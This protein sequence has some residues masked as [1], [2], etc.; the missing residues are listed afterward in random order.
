MSNLSA[1][2]PFKILTLALVVGA[3]GQLVSSALAQ[4]VQIASPNNRIKALL[5]P[6]ATGGLTYRVTV[7]GKSA[8]EPSSLGITVDGQNLGQQAV[9]GKPTTGN[10]KETYAV[11]GVH[12][13][14]VNSYHEAIF[15]LKS[16]D[17]KMPWQLEVRVFDD[18]VALRYRVPAQGQ[19][20]IGGETTT[21][22]LP[23]GSVVWYQTNINEYENAFQ[24]QQVER[25]ATD[26]VIGTPLTAKLPHGLGYA[27]VTEANLVKYSNLSL[28]AHGDQTFGAYFGSDKDGWSSDG[29]IVSPWRVTM[30]A[31]DLNGLVNSDLLRNLCPPPAPELANATWIKPGRGNWHWLVTGHPRLEAQN[32]WVD[33]T[34]KLGFEYYLIDDGWRDWK[35]GDKGQWENIKDVVNYATPHGVKIWAWVNS[36]EVFSPTDRAAYFQKAKDVGLVGLKIDFPERPNSTWVQWYD[37]TLRDAAKYQLMIDFHGAVKPTGRERTW[38]NELTREAILG[39]ESGKLPASHD[40]ALP[41]TR[42]VQ[43]H[44][45]FTPTDFRAG[46]LNGSSWTHELAQAIVYTSPFLCYGGSPENYLQNPGVDILKALPST[47]DETIVLPGSEV[48]RTAAFARRKGREWFIGVVNG[49]EDRPFHINLDFLTKGPFEA[50]TMTDLA[51]NNA[52]W[53]RAQKTVTGK[54][55]LTFNVRG[56]GGFVARLMP[57][58]R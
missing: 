15:P 35:S 54:D 31:P 44:A 52:G 58:G 18:G 21:W 25:M 19:H 27:F 13:T 40:T 39:R 50:D 30:L 42:Y 22:K 14:A 12:T 29:E 51:D 2:R 6:S 26:A 55:S 16:G 17:G 7:G 4:E 3:S 45:D 8:I 20:K 33:W 57:L 37:D 5:T 53:K 1:K 9:I 49:G 10:F 32:Q 11:V 34:Q 41:F 23:T 36:H 48:G 47:W 43:G 46:R 56:N 38:P 28:Q 24:E